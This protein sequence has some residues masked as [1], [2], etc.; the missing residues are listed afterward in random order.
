MHKAIEEI[1]KSALIKNHD[2]YLA[3]YEEFATGIRIELQSYHMDGHGAEI[4]SSFFDLINGEIV[5]K[6]NHKR[7]WQ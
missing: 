3:G 6:W 1:Y 7:A 5:S 4:W 2:R